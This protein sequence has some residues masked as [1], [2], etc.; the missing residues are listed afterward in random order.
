MYRDVFPFPHKLCTYI[1][2]LLAFIITNI[3]RTL[4]Q[5]QIISPT[6]ISFLNDKRL[7]ILINIHCI[8]E[9][10]YDSHG[11]TATKTFYILISMFVVRS[12]PI[13]SF[14]AFYFLKVCKQHCKKLRVKI[15]KSIF[16]VLSTLII[17]QLQSAMQSVHMWI[18]WKKD[19][20]IHIAELG[21]E[22]KRRM[23]WMAAGN[24]TEKHSPTSLC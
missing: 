23:R 13:F 12:K 7:H 15:H 24:R 10:H 5:F 9:N 3:K 11:T 21:E 1:T 6:S 2:C 8:K 4:L 18:W 19:I 22:R 14:N 17:M 16:P 20:G